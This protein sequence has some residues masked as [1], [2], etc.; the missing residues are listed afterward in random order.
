MIPECQTK[1]G[2]GCPLLFCAQG[3][4]WADDFE[5]AVVDD[6]AA[7]TGRLYPRQ[8]PTL[9]NPGTSATFTRYSTSETG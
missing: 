1:R 3:T 4:L 8:I 2:T 5:F 6:A 7:T 9:W